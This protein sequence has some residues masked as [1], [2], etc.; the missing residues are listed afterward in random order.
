MD[1]IQQHMLD[2]YRAAQRSSPRRHPRA[3][4]TARSCA[5]LQTLAHTPPD[6]PHRPVQ[7]VRRLRAE[8]RGPAG[9]EQDPG[10]PGGPAPNEPPP[11]EAAAIRILTNPATASRTSPAD[12]SSPAPPTVTS[13]N[14]VPGGSP[15]PPVPAEPAPEQGH[16]RL[17]RLP[18]RRLVQHLR[19]V[20]QPD[21]E[22]MRVR[23]LR[24]HPEPRHPRRREPV[25]QRPGHHL[26]VGHVRREARQLP[27]QSD[28]RGSAA[29]NCL[30]ELAPYR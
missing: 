14:D 3:A 4:T 29:G 1:A 5:N 12:D 10:Q 30:E 13:V 20:R 11:H 8:P 28:Q 16:P 27:L 15:A 21:L 17:L 18:H 22:L 7:P 24:M 19:P 26:R 23:R 25:R 2:T 6:S 9:T